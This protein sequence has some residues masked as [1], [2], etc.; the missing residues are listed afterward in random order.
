MFGFRIISSK[1]LQAMQQSEESFKG[2]ITSK[3]E[4]ISSLKDQVKILADKL[5]K[6]DRKRLNGRF[7][8][9]N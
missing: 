9:S 2:I 8:K 4:E 5:S 3:D 1:K 7:C 6:F